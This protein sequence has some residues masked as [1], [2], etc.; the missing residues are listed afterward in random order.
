MTLDEATEEALCFGWIDGQLKSLDE[1][2]YTLRYTPRTANSIW[3]VSNIRRVE[4]LIAAGGMTAAGQ[5]KIDEAQGQRAVGCGHP[6]RAGGRHPRGV[7]KRAAAEAGRH[8]ILIALPDTRKKQIIYWL[9][10]AKTEK[11]RQTRI[12]KIMEAGPSP[13][14]VTH[15]SGENA[16]GPLTNVS[17]SATELRPHA[18]AAWLPRLTDEELLHPVGEHWTVAIVFA[19]LA[20]WDRRVMVV[21][22]M[23]E[24]NGKLFVPEIDLCVNDLSLPLWAAIPAAVPR[25]TSALPR[26][27]NWTGDW[28]PTRSPCLRR[29]YAYNHAV[30]D[31][32]AASI[33]ASALV[34]AEAALARELPRLSLTPKTTICAV[35]M[36]CR[37]LWECKKSRM[38]N[39]LLGKRVLI[40]QSTEF[41]DRCSARS[42]LSKAPT[43]SPAPMTL[44]SL[45]P[46]GALFVTPDELMSWSL[47][48]ALKAPS[49]AAVEV[50]ESEWRQVFSALVDPLR[51]CSAPRFRA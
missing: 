10:S 32:R 27:R 21:L 7:G 6:P 25:P 33:A 26:R 1:R 42:S 9:E 24:R 12:D 8:R 36:D 41:M 38:E 44:S 5:Q 37:R 13:A 40:T 28:K 29:S 14:R 17:S 35:L 34:E 22:D 2:R 18:C 51:A 23:T 31:P 30:G 20:W 19:H 49:T 50:T 39:T 45:A 15:D 11:T 4:Q 16:D 46:P 43:L 48:L 3:S 47:N